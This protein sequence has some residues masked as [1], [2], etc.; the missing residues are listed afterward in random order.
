LKV[1]GSPSS[2]SG[3]TYSSES[4]L[5]S[6]DGFVIEI[7]P[8]GGPNESGV[9]P[10]SIVRRPGSSSSEFLI[11]AG[12]EKPADC[13]QATQFELVDG[14]LTSGGGGAEGVGE[15]RRGLGAAPGG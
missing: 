9:A 6:P 12:V 11:N 10:G 3:A 7:G 13:S 14:E 5:P 1:L 8:A 4:A 15:S 2:V